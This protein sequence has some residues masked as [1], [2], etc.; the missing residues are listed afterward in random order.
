MNKPAENPH[1]SHRR[2]I[3]YVDE[4]LQ[5]FL[6]VGLVLLE[7]GLAA[8]LAWLMYQH[9]N[10]IIDDNMYRVHLADATSLL[11]QLI[12]QSYFLLGLFFAVN[13]LALVAVDLVWRRYVHS[14]LRSFMQLMTK[15]SQLDFSFDPAIA[16]RHQLLDL[17]EAQRAQDRARLTAI[18]AQLSLL[19]PEVSTA[20]DAPTVQR[21][22]N[23]LNE[24]LPNTTTTPP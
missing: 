6:L 12:S 10:Q 9:L 5:K 8:G 3:H 16:R 4:S 23:A 7:A 2:R 14:I 15:T 22:L 20:T 17:S 19:S 18:R 13:V 11:P 24:L 1:N 21:V